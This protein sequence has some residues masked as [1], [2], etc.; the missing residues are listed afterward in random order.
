MGAGT[1][2]REPH[3]ERSGLQGASCQQAL[4]V[5]F[6]A[7]RALYPSII[8]KFQNKRIFFQKSFHPR[9]FA[10]LQNSRPDKRTESVGR[11]S[12]YWIGEAICTRIERFEER[13]GSALKRG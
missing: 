13:P 2:A 4:I 11:T 8:P 6:S 10:H 7:N 3:P 1:R 12:K 9:K 5:Y